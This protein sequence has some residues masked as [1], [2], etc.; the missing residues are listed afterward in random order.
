MGLVGK[1]LYPHIKEKVSL[2]VDMDS[3]LHGKQYQNHF[4]SPPDALK[5]LAPGSFM[6]L[7]T[8]LS[9]ALPSALSDHDL[10][11][12]RAADWLLSYD[13]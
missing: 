12:I 1:L 13:R 4:I 11:V 7:F 2:V 8:P 9:R 5:A 6:V 10:T 3:G